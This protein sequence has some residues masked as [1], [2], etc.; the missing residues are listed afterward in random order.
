MARNLAQREDVFEK[1]VALR[2]EETTLWIGR[3]QH[4][5]LRS[6]WK[7]A[8]ND[9]AKVIDARPISDESFEYAAP[10]LLLDDRSRYN[11]YCQQLVAQAGDPQGLDAYYLARVCA[12]GPADGIDAARIVQWAGRGL[13]NRPY[14]TLT[15]LAQAQ[16]RAGQFELAI[17]NFQESNTLPAVE[18]LRARNFFGLA[19]AYFRSE[20]IVAAQES[21]EQARQRF[22]AAQPT[23][24]GEK[25]VLEVPSE[26]IELNVLSHETEAFSQVR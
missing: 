1:V 16:A 11:E 12:I 21:L 24:P 25:T 23:K 5:A 14:W 19:N 18:A 15:L 8:A 4:R 3:G 17:Q 6:L 20:Q 2:P 9:Y 13:S 26:W 10:P 22:H 7:D